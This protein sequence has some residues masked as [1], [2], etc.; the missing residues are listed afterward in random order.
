MSE[1]GRDLQVGDRVRIVQLPSDWSR[2]DWRVDAST[3][4]LYRWLIERRR[5]V[6]VS[7][8][9]EYGQPWIWCRSRQSG[10]RWIHHAL[11]LADDSWVRVKPRSVKRERR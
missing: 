4:R 2:P 9:D 1:H 10:G 11:A 7:R 3:R 5:S 6:R 8:L